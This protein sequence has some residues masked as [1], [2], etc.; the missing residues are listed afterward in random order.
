VSPLKLTCV[1]YFVVPEIKAIAYGRYMAMA[2][3]GDWKRI[4]SEFR[5]QAL[6][7]LVAAPAP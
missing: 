7:F 3:V 1:H 4:E 6:S 5:K 2:D